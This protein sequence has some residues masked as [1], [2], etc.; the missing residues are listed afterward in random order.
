MQD[1]TVLDEKQEIRTKGC[2]VRK[3]MVVGG[4]ETRCGFYVKGLCARLGMTVFPYE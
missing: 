4:K 2:S 1:K 3:K